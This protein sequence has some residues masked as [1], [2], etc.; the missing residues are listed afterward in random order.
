MYLKAIAHAVP[1]ARFSQSEVWEAFR[2]SPSAQRL[3]SRSVDLVRRVL[4]GD[5]G[6]DTRHFALPQIPELFE[7][8]AETLN[9][10]FE[11]EAPVLALRALQNACAEAAWRPQE[12]D[13]LFVC[14]CTGYLCPGVSSHVAEQAGMR[15]NAYLQDLVGLGCGAALPTLESARHFLIAHPE[16]TVAVVA[17]EVCS[18][19][20]YMDD[21]PGVIISACLFGDGASATLWSGSQAANPAWRLHSY[22]QWHQPQER[23]ILRFTNRG[24]KL[25][26]QLT[27]VVPQKASQ[28]VKRLYAE[29]ATRPIDRVISHT[30]GRDV[31]EAIGAE[32]PHETLAESRRTLRAFGNMSSPS[33]LFALEDCLKSE[34]TPGELWLTAFGAGFSTY[35]CR[36]SAV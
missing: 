17:V 16:A 9:E 30:G 11:R 36:L 7:Y 2:D 19:A 13:A 29:A 21:D 31:I 8:G 18:A 22:Q 12:L 23:E 32:L 34:G 33:V 4:L 20:F 5:N 28:A 1:S 6:V 24:G 25:R 3:R 27:K 14:T 26:N 15:S 10:G 35:A